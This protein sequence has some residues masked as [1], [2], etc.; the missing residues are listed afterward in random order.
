MS[1]MCRY[2]LKPGATVFSA[3]SKTFFYGKYHRDC[4]GKAM[5]EEAASLLL[6]K[7]REL[8]DTVKFWAKA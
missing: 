7:R 4:I 6:F 8:D 5:R 3:P 1:I 2:C